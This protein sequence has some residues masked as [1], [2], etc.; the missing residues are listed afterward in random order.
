[1][2]RVRAERVAAFAVARGSVVQIHG[3]GP[4]KAVFV[5]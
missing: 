5:K 2:V 3:V 4:F 1:V